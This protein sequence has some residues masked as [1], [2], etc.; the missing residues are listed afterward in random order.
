MT[1]VLIDFIGFDGWKENFYDE[2]ILLKT[3]FVCETIMCLLL[4]V[5]C[6]IILISVN[7]NNNFILFFQTKGPSAYNCE[8]K[9]IDRSAKEPSRKLGFETTQT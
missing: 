1:F 8:A 2:L 3:N 9:S 4:Y 6:L 5:Y 7:T